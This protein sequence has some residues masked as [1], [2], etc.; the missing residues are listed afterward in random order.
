[1]AGAIG[2]ART[3]ASTPSEVLRSC[4][5]TAQFHVLKYRSSCAIVR[6]TELGGRMGF[7]FRRSIRLMPGVRLNVGRKSASASI[8]IRGLS[9]TA[10]SMGRRVT[11]GLPGTGLY[12]T[13]ELRN[14]VGGGMRA[15][16]SLVGV[17]I[18]FCLAIAALTLLGR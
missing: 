7:R 9:Y 3:A 11:V 13:R 12:W 2:E 4:A 10:G 17:L 18:L 16:L 15:S 6:Y 5:A 1:M 8:G 14:G